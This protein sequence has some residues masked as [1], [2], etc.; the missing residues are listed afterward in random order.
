MN[1]QNNK[2]M[3]LKETNHG[4]FYA[5]EDEQNANRK[6]VIYFHKKVGEDQLWK[7]QKC[8][9]KLPQEG[10]SLEDWIFLKEVGEK[11]EE[12]TNELNEE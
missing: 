5:F 12:L 6:A 1:N 11:I 4:K 7:F 9:T 2:H 3:P 8:D 10:A